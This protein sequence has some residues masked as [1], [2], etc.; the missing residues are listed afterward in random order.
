MPINMNAMD[1]NTGI[2]Y[3]PP[4]KKSLP[5]PETGNEKKDNLS[6]YPAYPASEDIYSKYQ[7]EKNINPEDITKPKEQND[8]GLNNEKDFNDDVSGSDLDIPGAEMDDNQED[9]GSEDEENNY[10]SL[11]DDSPDDLE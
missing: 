6:G 1:N 8:T 10:Y 4:R 5:D 2:P 7:E 9:I 11:G 3:R